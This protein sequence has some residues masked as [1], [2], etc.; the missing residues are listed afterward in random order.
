MLHT[1]PP[2]LPRLRTSHIDS[3]VI[4]YTLALSIATALVIGLFPALSVMRR[5]RQALVGGT[6]GAVTDRNTLRAHR[7]LV[8][9]DIA[10]AVILLIGASLL[11]RS[12]QSLMRVSPGFNSDGLV[13]AD[14]HLA[15]DRYATR[16]D[17]LQFFDRAERRIAALPGISAVSAIDRLPYGQSFSRI[18]LGIGDV[19]NATDK[20][21]AFNASARPGYFAAIG[22][23]MLKGREF[24]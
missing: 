20:P 10:F 18:P 15:S 24:A 13:T 12:Y 8:A 16:A 11:L 4:L 2:D 3:A 9:S 1:A 6:R 21:V 14:V 22:I 23:P 19:G 7:F 17:V 5:Q